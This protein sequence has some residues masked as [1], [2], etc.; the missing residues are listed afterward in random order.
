MT[1]TACAVSH[2]EGRMP[3]PRYRVVIEGELGPRYASAFDGMT[4][5]ARN[6]KT[7]IVGPITDSSHLHGL[8]ERI[9]SLGLRLHS[10]TPLETE[11]IESRGPTRTQPTSLNDKVPGVYPTGP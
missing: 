5:R 2:A 11:D 8:L 3:A 4:I 9:A 1:Q 6:G 7:E 10:L